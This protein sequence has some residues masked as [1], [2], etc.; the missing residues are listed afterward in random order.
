MKISESI[1]LI[2]EVWKEYNKQKP[3]ETP[4]KVPEDQKVPVVQG[5]YDFLLRGVPAV[6]SRLRN[7]RTFYKKYEGLNTHSYVCA[8]TLV[9]SRMKPV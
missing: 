6:D 2:P 8:E 5:N 3:A 7:L 1:S 4:E 9:F